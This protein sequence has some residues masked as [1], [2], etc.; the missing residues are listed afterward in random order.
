MHSVAVGAV[1]AVVVGAVAVA[2]VAVGAAVAAVTGV[3]GAVAVIGGAGVPY[4]A[5]SQ[6]LNGNWAGVAYDNGSI[7]G[8]AAC[9]GCWFWRARFKLVRNSGASSSTQNPLLSQTTHI[10]S[11]SCT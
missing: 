7:M 2:A 8:G 6:A 9:Q 5:G 10:W 11:L 1:G 3:L 4:D